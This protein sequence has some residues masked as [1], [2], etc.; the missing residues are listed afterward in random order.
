MEKT[1]FCDVGCGAG[2]KLFWGCFWT[3]TFFGKSAAECEY[4]ANSGLN[5]F[6]ENLLK[7]TK[8]RGEKIIENVDGTKMIRRV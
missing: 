5:F 1:G 7:K 4:A 2:L 8:S 3:L 6:L